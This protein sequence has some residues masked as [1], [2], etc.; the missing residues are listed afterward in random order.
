MMPECSKMKCIQIWKSKKF[1]KYWVPYKK[2]FKG[3]SCVDTTMFDDKKGNRW[4]FIN[5]SNDKY[6]DHNSELYIYKTDKKFIKLTPHKL[7]PVIVDSR[8]ARNAGNIYYNK[9]G[10]IVRPS[11]RNTHNFYGR[12]LN[13]RIITKLNINEFTEVDY[14]SYNSDFKNNI[15]AIH[16]ITQNNNKY[17]IDVRYK[18]FLFYFMP[19]AY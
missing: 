15:N 2:L 12:A 13:M 5:K 10:Q 19:N 18:K 14:I 8:Y 9:K 11:Q 1:P 7:N 16:H 3:E 4:L 6:N 17:V